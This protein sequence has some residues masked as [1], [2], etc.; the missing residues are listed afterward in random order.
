MFQYSGSEYNQL[1][2]NLSNLSNNSNQLGGVD[3]SQY[4]TKTY[5]DNKTGFKKEIIEDTT[6]TYTKWNDDGPFVMNSKDLNATIALKFTIV[7]NGTLG[8]ERGYARRMEIRPNVNKYVSSGNYTQSLFTLVGN[9]KNPVNFSNS[10]FSYFTT[11]GEGGNILVTDGTE[12][13]GR[14][15]YGSGYGGKSSDPGIVYISTD[16]NLFSTGYRMAQSPI[17]IGRINLTIRYMV[18]K[19]YFG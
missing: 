9:E 16:K 12:S 4:A 7:V 2:P 5:V 15:L 11:I 19:Y 6:H 18:T 14:V 1:N 10:T 17:S 13:G 3:S 8:G